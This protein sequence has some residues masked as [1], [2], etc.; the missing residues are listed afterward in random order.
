MVFAISSPVSALQKRP[1]RPRK[2][3][4]IWV[5]FGLIQVMIWK[6]LCNTILFLSDDT[7]ILRFDT[8]VEREK[9]P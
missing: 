8:A 9:Q 5:F 2:V 1:N 3:G 7:E 4:V 6:K